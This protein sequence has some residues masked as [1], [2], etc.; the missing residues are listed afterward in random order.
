MATGL[1]VVAS[2]V[3]GVVELVRDEVDGILCDAENVAQFSEAIVGLARDPW[4]R[5]GLGRSA[6]VRVKD[7]FALPIASAKTAELLDEVHAR[8]S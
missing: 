1:P 2:R 8:A 6:R 7:R 4:R 5:R 3:G